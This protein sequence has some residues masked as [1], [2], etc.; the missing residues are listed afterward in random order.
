VAFVD[1]VRLTWSLSP[2]SPAEELTA[3]P[4]AAT[5]RARD[6]ASAITAGFAP[7]PSDADSRRPDG[8]G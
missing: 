4:T 3:R 1:R 5:G 6:P 2:H 7:S 8:Q